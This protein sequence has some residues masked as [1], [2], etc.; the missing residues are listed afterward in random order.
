[1][2]INHLRRFLK[3]VDLYRKAGF[4]ITLD[5]E[6]EISM[7]L[8]ELTPRLK[9]GTEGYRNELQ[10]NAR[11]VVIRYEFSY[12]CPSCGLKREPEA[13]VVNWKFDRASCRECYS[14]GWFHQFKEDLLPFGLA[15]T[16]SKNVF[17]QEAFEKASVRSSDE[18]EA[19]KRL[20]NSN[21]ADEDHVKNYQEYM[22]IRRMSGLMEEIV[23]SSSEKPA[24]SE[25]LDELNK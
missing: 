11:I 13:W 23:E 17:E 14:N 4:P 19:L 18:I 8:S 2:L 25:Y 20:S 7:V 5:D 16:V 12:M 24:N 3:N 9:P 21:K 10:K 6:Y 22:R 1:M 15:F